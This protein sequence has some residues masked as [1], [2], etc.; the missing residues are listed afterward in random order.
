MARICLALTE[1]TLE[2]NLKILTGYSGQIDMAEL[3]CDFLTEEEMVRVSEFPGLTDL[4]LILTFRKVCDGGKFNRDEEI[5]L[6]L[7]EKAL[8]GNFSF[9]DLEEGLHAPALEKKARERGI[10]IIRSFHDF[11]KVPENLA[12]RLINSLHSSDEIPKAAVMPK[13]TADLKRIFEENEKLGDRD[14]I[15]LGM[16][17]Y[18][19]STRILAGVMGSYLTFC[20]KEGGVTAAPGHVSPE[21]L[22]NIY[23]FRNINSETVICGIIGHP[24]MHTRSP[25]IHNEGYS[26]LGLNYVYIPFETDDV[27][28]FFSLAEKLSIRGFSVTVP[29][30]NDVIPLL[31]EMSSGVKA[32]GACNTV[33][34]KEGKWFGE[35]TDAEGFIIPL[36]ALTELK[37]KRVS[38]IGAGGAAKACVFALLEEGCSVTIFNRT[39][40]KARLLAEQ[41]SCSSAPLGPD[42]LEA[43]KESS[44]IL[45]QTTSAG[46]HPMEDRN[47]LDFYDFT[48]EETAY[49]IIYTPEKT[50]FLL[51]AEKKGCAILNGYEM[52]K[53]QGYKQF[54]L[55]TG[56]EYPRA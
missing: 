27:K 39:Y 25:L 54:K 28:E 2:E 1:S 34:K 19:F 40:E 56:T 7:M 12:E 29:H 26:K 49:D 38:V 31:D 32:I 22:N 4:P 51:E 21:V 8:N 50:L 3:R 6:S 45:V 47:P 15:L 48:G 37:N 10:R 44:D 33:W 36:R 46:M 35:N 14:K 13:S 43:L 41:M 5:R 16:G 53:E 24:V 23:R 11:D 20:S 55:F 9:V 18:G 17:T 52:L 30:K 42:S